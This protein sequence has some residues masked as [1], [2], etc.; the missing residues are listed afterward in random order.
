MIRGLPALTIHTV[1]AQSTKVYRRNAKSARVRAWGP[2]LTGLAVVP[3]LPY[4]FDEPVEHVTDLAFDW[5][6]RKWYEGK[7]SESKKDL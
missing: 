1:V 6:K 3:L 7:G 5:M 2:T 4:L